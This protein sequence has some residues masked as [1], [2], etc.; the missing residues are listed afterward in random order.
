MLSDCEVFYKSRRG[1][2]LRAPLKIPIENC[3]PNVVREVFTTSA[4]FRIL[5]T[6]T[7]GVES[8]GNFALIIL[9]SQHFR[10]RFVHYLLES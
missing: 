5:G 1:R 7:L 4:Y 6:S 2:P 10:K 9:V 8:W 3:E